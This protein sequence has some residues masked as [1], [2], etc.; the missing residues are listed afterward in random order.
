MH[1]H[2]HSLKSTGVG[3][4]MA[5]THWE[6]PGHTGSPQ[7]CAKGGSGERGGGGPPW[8]GHGEHR[9]TRVLPGLWPE[10]PGVPRGRPGSSPQP[11]WGRP[12]GAPRSRS[13]RRCPVRE[14]GPR[15]RRPSGVSRVSVATSAGRSSALPLPKCPGGRGRAGAGAGCPAAAAAPRPVSGPA[16]RHRHRH[17]RRGGAGLDRAGPGLPL[18][19]GWERWHGAPGAR[20]ERSSPLA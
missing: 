6:Y 16:G 3:V 18:S 5:E 12:S 19:A 20:R 15:L 4:G 17:R 10:E 9:G 11:G 1:L 8:E 2:W 14:G 13:R 7:G